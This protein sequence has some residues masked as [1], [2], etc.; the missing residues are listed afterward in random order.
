MHHQ[1]SPISR[2]THLD[3][4]HTVLM[5]CNTQSGAKKKA[6]AGPPTTVGLTWA[7]SAQNATSGERIA[8]GEGNHSPVATVPASV[9]PV[10]PAVGSPVLGVQDLGLNV[11]SHSAPDKAQ[12]LPQGT[13][14][15]DDEDSRLLTLPSPSHGRQQSLPASRSASPELQG[16]GRRRCRKGGDADAD[17][18]G[19]KRKKVGHKADGAGL[20]MQRLKRERRPTTKAAEEK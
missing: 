13:H 8:P 17:S 9:H 5:A 18:P 10:V 20:N 16:R 14:N 11:G 7:S 3:L 4:F 2:L 19:R 15:A 1:S 12:Q 6:V